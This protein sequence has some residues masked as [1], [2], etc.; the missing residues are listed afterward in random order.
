MAINQLQAPINYMAMTPQVDLGGSFA[1][2]G[3][4]LAQRQQRQQTQEAKQQFSNDLQ[5]AQANGG[6]QAWLNMIGKY[7]QFREAFGDVRKGLGEEQVKNEFSSG[8]DV[9]TAL[10]N[11]K[12]EVAKQKLQVLI[13]AN[14]NSGKPTGIYQQAYDLIDSGEITA[15][16]AGINKALSI[17]DPDRFEKTVKSQTTA[18][19][20]PSEINEA[21]AKAKTAVETAAN[22]PARAKAEADLAVANADKAKVEANFAE[23]LAQAGL[24]KSNWDIKNL[25]STISDR[26]QRLALDKQTTAATVAEKFASINEKLG[27][28]PADT[29]KLINETAVI[30]STSKQAADQMNDLA[31]R[32]EGLGGYGAASRLG[33]F[34]KSTLGIEGYD[35]ALRQEYTRLRNQAAIKSLPPGPATDK[36]IEMAL[37]GFPK[38]TSD[39]KNVAQ[40]LRGMAKMQNIDASINN[41]KTDWLANNNGTLTRAK[42]T[43]I[44]GDYAAKPGETFNDFSQRIVTD[45]SKKA[46]PKQQTSLVEQ[47][48]TPRTPAPAQAQAISIEDQALAII[49]GGK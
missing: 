46:G 42:N 12:P 15:A 1:E 11:Q 41:A 9:S 48:P 3:Q 31:Q 2:L 24:N 14:K 30:A 33:E 16:K 36:D 37:R 10:E 28:I 34:A 45:V 21:I 6:Q 25:Q 7:P 27:T 19:K 43:F 32:I 26:S 5:A 4:V 29:R 39:S 18:A 17:L 35:T 8:F 20:A 22:A 23:K 38:D 13:D 49:R 40:F 47:I 44:A